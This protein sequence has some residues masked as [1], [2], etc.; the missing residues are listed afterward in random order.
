M[1]I[2][3]LVALL[4]IK[5]KR[6]IQFYMFN[7]IPQSGVLLHVNIAA[8]LSLYIAF[9]IPSCRMYISQKGYFPWSMSDTNT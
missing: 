3:Y 5:N 6:A 9:P 2:T 7:G 4:F 8:A 1:I